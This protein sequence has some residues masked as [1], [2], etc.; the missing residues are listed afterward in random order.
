MTSTLRCSTARLGA[1]SSDHLEGRLEAGLP[2]ANHSHIVRFSPVKKRTVAGRLALQRTQNSHRIRAMCSVFEQMIGEH[3]LL[4]RS[5]GDAQARCSRLI[6]AQQALIRQLEAQVIRL[7]AA[8]I[9]RD[10][11]LAFGLPVAAARS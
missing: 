8:V 11:A 1:S 2:N 7:R 10:T 9:V 3:V 5:Y 6:G 4:A